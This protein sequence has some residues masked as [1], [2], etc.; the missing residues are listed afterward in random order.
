MNEV[1]YIVSCFAKN[2][3]ATLTE[4]QNINKKIETMN[5]AI[6]A[7]KEMVSNGKS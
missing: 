4:I 3:V 5:E 1:Q 7:L 2:S 6:E